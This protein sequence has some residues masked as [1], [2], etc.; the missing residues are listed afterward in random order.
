MWEISFVGRPN[1]KPYQNVSRPSSRQTDQATTQRSPH[2][3]DQDQLVCFLHRCFGRD[4]RLVVHG[5][6]QEEAKLP[7]LPQEPRSGQGLR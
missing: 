4:R 2:Q 7:E 3:T 1:R 5:Q 6:L